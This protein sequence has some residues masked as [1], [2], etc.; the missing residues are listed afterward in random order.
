MS[1]PATYDAIGHPAALTRHDTAEASGQSTDFNTAHRQSVYQ[2]RSLL[3]RSDSLPH[4]PGP[5]GRVQSAP[6]GTLLKQTVARWPVQAGPPV[7]TIHYAM[8]N[9]I[10]DTNMPHCCCRWAAAGFP[11]RT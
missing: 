6:R 1:I 5:I 4:A 10:L 9:K 3:H 2:Q 7:F 11:E 8:N